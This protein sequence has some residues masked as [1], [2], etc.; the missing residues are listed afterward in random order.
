MSRSRIDRLLLTPYGLLDAGGRAWADFAAWC[1]RHP[2]RRVALFVG[3]ER[4]HSL[5]LP[6]DLPLPDD[7]ARLR[8][9]RLQFTHY[10]GPAAQ[11][12]PI[13]ASHDAACALTADDPAH[14]RATAAAHRVRLLSVRPSWTLAPA[15]DGPHALLDTRLLTRLSRSAGRLQQLHAQHVDPDSPP[16]APAATVLA[17]TQLAAAPTAPGPDFVPPGSRLRPLAWAWAATAAA[18][19]ALVAVQAQGLLEAFEPLAQ[20]AALLDRI[21]RATPAPAQAHLPAAA[22]GRAWQSARQLSLDW[23]ALWSPIEQALPG[24]LSLSSL[25]LDAQALRLEGQAATAEAVT[26]LVDRLTLRAAA[27]DEVVLTRLQQPAAAGGIEPFRFELV[28]R[29]AGAVR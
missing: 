21:T 29:P 3:A 27:G 19:C 23:G 12:W 17:Q 9:A 2:G 18:A 24:G 6:A 20:Q 4:L 13:A 11:D 10:F 28:R 16:A 1:E 26:Q 8:Y 22:R 14:W 7:D 5:L 15:D 25:E